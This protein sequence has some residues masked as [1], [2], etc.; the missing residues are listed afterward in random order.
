MNRTFDEIFPLLKRTV[1]LSASFVDAVPMDYATT[2]TNDTIDAAVTISVLALFL[3]VFFVGLCIRGGGNPGTRSTMSATALETPM[4]S[5]LVDAT[6]VCHNSKPV[7]VRYANG[8]GC[9]LQVLPKAHPT[10]AKKIM[11]SDTNARDKLFPLDLWSRTKAKIHQ[12]NVNRVQDGGHQSDRILSVEDGVYS[13]TND[14][15]GD[16]QT[17]KARCTA[18]A[19]NT[20]NNQVPSSLIVN[21]DEV[22]VRGDHSM[23][24]ELVAQDN[25]S[26]KTSPYAYNKLKRPEYEAHIKD[27]PVVRVESQYECCVIQS[28]DIDS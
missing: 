25:G 20:S 23:N 28:Q 3:T 10:K 26:K 1:I 7:K 5:T 14:N 18:V 2:E 21:E 6:S 11:Q 15:I 13:S 22:L 24:Q 12:A 27:I 19:M 9:S 8:T 4:A 17:S 16:R